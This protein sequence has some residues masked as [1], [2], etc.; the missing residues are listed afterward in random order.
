MQLREVIESTA[1]ASGLIL[2]IAYVSGRVYLSAYY[3]AFHIDFSDLGLS[4]QD[5]AFSS[6]HTFI[7]P[8]NAA[9]VTLFAYPVAER[10]RQGTPHPLRVRLSA[11]E[12]RLRVEGAT[13]SLTDEFA[14]LDKDIAIAEAGMRGDVVRW[15]IYS[16]FA[17]IAG[18]GITYPLIAAREGRAAAPFGAAALTS[19]GLGLWVAFAL[20]SAAIFIFRTRAALVSA[21]ALYLVAIT[22]VFPVVAGRLR[23]IEDSRAS[24]G[25]ALSTIT[26][27]SG[28]ALGPDWTAQAD[29]EFLSPSYR[30]LSRTNDYWI[31]WNPSKSDAT[32]YFR[33]TDITRAD[34]K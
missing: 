5:V 19:L 24:D 29:G 34:R 28:H 12:A 7:Y 1:A 25:G 30:L 32:T 15:I 3:T 8:L 33:T 6:W 4:V 23:G 22:F 14:T 20:G 21:L 2:L 27:V 9:V 31:V 26:L 13:A 18:G 16:L 11:I 10:L 17:A